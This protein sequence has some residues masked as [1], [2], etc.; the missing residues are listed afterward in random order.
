[1]SSHGIEGCKKC[2]L[3]NNNWNAFSS[4]SVSAKM[5]DNKLHFDIFFSSPRRCTSDKESV[6]II[7]GTDRA[8]WHRKSACRRI[9]DAMNV[10]SIFKFRFFAQD[11]SCTSFIWHWRI[12]D[13]WRTE[14]DSET[15]TV[16]NQREY[17]SMNNFDGLSWLA[18]ESWWWWIGRRITKKVNQRSYPLPLFFPARKL[19]L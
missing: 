8:I 18:I 10:K 14:V 7:V 4:D 1:M 9:S 12:D 5:G 2:H 6:E 17:K 3:I 13:G 15:D 19:N 16:I 11:V